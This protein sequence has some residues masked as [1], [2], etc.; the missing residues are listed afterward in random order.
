MSNLWIGLGV[1]AV[2]LTSFFVIM[3]VT[4]KAFLLI[5]GPNEEPLHSKWIPLQVYSGEDS[6]DHPD[7]MRMLEMS[8]LEDNKRVK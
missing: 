4:K 1:L 6:L 3:A 5:K 8:E 7:L 2:V